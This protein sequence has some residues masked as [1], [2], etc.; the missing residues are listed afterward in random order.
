[1]SDDELQREIKAIKLLQDRSCEIAES[2]AATVNDLKVLKDQVADLCE[3]YSVQQALLA[4][5]TE[6]ELGSAKCGEPIPQVE[7]S[8]IFRE[9]E[10]RYPE[11]LGVQSILSSQDQKE[12][13]ERL[14]QKIQLFNARYGLEA[15]DY[16]I[17]VSCGLFAGMLDWFAVK[18]PPGPT[19]MKWSKEV[20]G[21]FNRGVQKAFNKFLTPELSRKLSEACPIG[22]PDTSIW[23]HLVDAPAKALNPENHRLRSLAHDPVLGFI[24]GVLDM[25]NGTCTAVVNG[26]ISSFK[27]NAKK[28]IRVEGNIFQLLGRM[29][30]H[31]LSDVNAPSPNGNRGMGLPAPFMGLLRMFEGIPFGNSNFGREIEGMYVK[32]YDFRQF[33]VTSVP[34][35]IMEV[36]LRAFFTAKQMKLHDA[37]FG[38]TLLDTMP[39]RMNPRFRMIL[40]MAYGTSS[41]LNAGKMCIS[42]NLL[43]ANY[44]SWMG[45][46]WNSF[47]SLKWVLLDKHLKL[48]EG[49][50]AS[51]I[52]ELEHI[53]DQV[54]KLSE[55]ATLLPIAG[56]D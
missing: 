11:A 50:K 2:H 32:G 16:A 9:A 48:W 33:V 47:H 12:L 5:T 13:E 3:T 4:T 49:I 40:A 25:S 29:L 55:R 37:P 28:M 44:A 35:A 43:D 53:V 45:L 8:E 7:L 41:A 17:A 14:A 34:M 51:E 21:V 26:K 36:L 6:E 54:D 15:W 1:M 23:R 46:A 19:K 56:H 22:A 39:F 52:E 20:D 31:L 27:I 10:S 42:K 24:F 18:A 30:G 38:E